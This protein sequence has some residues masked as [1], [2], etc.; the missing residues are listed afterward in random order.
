MM[1]HEKSG[2]F[3]LKFKQS[4]S[5]LPQ[6]NLIFHDAAEIFYVHPEYWKTVL[7]GE[8]GTFVFNCKE[9]NDH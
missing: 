8:T 7:T 1:F 2:W 4:H 5:V 9:P 3:S 6:H